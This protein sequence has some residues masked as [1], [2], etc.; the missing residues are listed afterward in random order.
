[1]GYDIVSWLIYVKIIIFFRKQIWL[2]DFRLLVL[3]N[4]REMSGQAE[5]VPCV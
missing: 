1:M 3:L 5:S 4:D 2:P